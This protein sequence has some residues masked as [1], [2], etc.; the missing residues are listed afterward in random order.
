MILYIS[1][2]QYVRAK[3][4]SIAPFEIESDL[5]ASADNKHTMIL[6]LSV[7]LKICQQDQIIVR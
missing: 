2:S 1:A 7:E 3:Q 5:S 6:V 4:T